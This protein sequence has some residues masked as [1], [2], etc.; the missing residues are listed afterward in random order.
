MLGRVTLAATAALG[1]AFGLGGGYAL[2]GRAPDWFAGHA[3]RDL[4]PGPATDL[5]AYGERIVA[6]TA[7]HIGPEA[8]DPALRYAGNDLACTNCHMK[9]GLQ[10]LAAPFVSTFTSYPLMADDRVVT[11]TDRINGC[12]TRSMNGKSLPEASREMQGLVAYI[13]FLGRGSPADIRV[14]G[15]GLAQLAPPP[16][17]P[18]AERGAALYAGQCARCH[19][20]DGQGR[21]RDASSRVAGYEFP[22]LWG[23]ASFNDAAGMSR[24]RMAAGFIAANMPYGVD[25]GAPPLA[26]QAAWDIA[27]FVTA[28][29]RPRG[30][31]RTD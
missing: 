8:A 22:P 19:G 16:Q 4:A 21:Y 7:R 10:R 25:Q 15:M 6:D 5:I 20:A 17:P 30:P 11:L 27:A 3:V 24:L 9:A 26:P 31:A 14:P 18:S 1:I 28:Q 12:M 13:Q 23:E 29:A 2:W